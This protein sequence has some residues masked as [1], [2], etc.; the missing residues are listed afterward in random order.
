MKRIYYF[1]IILFALSI[2]NCGKE[3]QVQKNTYYSKAFSDSAIQY[4]KS[5]LSKEDFATLDII[6]INTLKYKEIN[7]AVKVIQKGTLGQRFIL[8]HKSINGFEGNWVDLSSLIKNT[9]EEY[10]GKVVLSTLQNNPLNEFTVLNNKVTKILYPDKEDKAL[11]SSNAKTNRTNISTPDHPE[12]L[13]EVIVIGYIS[14]QPVSFM[15]FYW[16]FNQDSFYNNVYSSGFG[17]G[18]GSN[19]SNNVTIA[20]KFIS[21][22]HPTPDIKK[23]LKCFTMD[24][25]STYWVTINVNQPVPN[26]RDLGNMDSRYVV[27][28]TY[29]TLEEGFSN[30][31]S[32]IRNVGFYPVTG[33]KPGSSIDKSVFGDDSNTPFSVSLKI[34]MS[35]NEFN[36]LLS[37]ISSNQLQ[38]F[39]LNNFNCTSSTIETFNSV[40]IHLPSTK[41]DAPLYKGNN[42]AD[43]GQD[44]RNMDL[45]KFSSENGGR[46]VIRN[47]SKNNANNINPPAKAGVC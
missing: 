34:S 2:S 41:S 47:V 29:M 8:L 44:I 46:K 7:L 21:P 3:N 30:G 27:G 24:S 40:N 39:D 36:T 18:G 1:L 9:P 12:M 20:P 45:N 13:D 6:S 19:T 33:A 42:P 22:D 28:H 5:Q 35:G 32:V 4:L 16:M 31:N 14:S 11:T 25:K 10:S 26:S 23:E 43:L 15:S 17:G 38:N 37:T